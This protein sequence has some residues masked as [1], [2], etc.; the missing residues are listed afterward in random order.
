VAGQ[1]V[2]SGRT[3][4]VGKRF[5]GQGIHPLGN[6]EFVGHE[7]VESDVDRPVRTDG[8]PISNECVEH[9]LEAVDPVRGDLRHGHR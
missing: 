4:F 9:L 5:V 6:A 8:V 3:Y 2:P 7:V 1:V